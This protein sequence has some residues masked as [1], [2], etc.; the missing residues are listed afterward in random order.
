[1]GADTLTWAEYRGS[2]PK[3]E[4]FLSEL[5]SHPQAVVL[6][7]GSG[8]SGKSYAIRSA[9]VHLLGRYRMLGHP[10]QKVMVACST[11]PLLRDRHINK[12]AE[13][14]ASFGKIVDDRLYGL[15]FRFADESLGRVLFRNLDEPGKYRGTE[16]AAALVDELTELPEFIGGEPTLATLLYPIRSPRPLPFLPFGAGS[17]PDGVGYGWVKKI[18]VDRNFAEYGLKP[19]Q[20]KY[21]PALVGDNPAAGPEM[22]AR[23]EAL[24]ER[25]KQARLYGSWD[26]PEGARWPQL[27]KSVHMFDKRKDWPS[28]LPDGW[29]VIVGIDYGVNAPYA[30]LWIAIDPRGDCWVY[31]EDYEK[32]LSADQQAERVANLT[33]EN[34]TISAI[35]LDPAMWARGVTM[36][37]AADIYT[38]KFRAHKMPAPLPGF[39]RSRQ[40]AMSTIDKMLNRENGFGNLWIDRS[41]ENLW[42]EMVSAVWDTRGM[43]AG[44]REDIDPR[45][46]DH[47]I[48]A[49][50]YALHTHLQV[51]KDKNEDATVDFARARQHQLEE[52]FKQ[53][54]RSFTKPRGLPWR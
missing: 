33:A 31:R 40:I 53:S 14:M 36:V 10:A 42:R 26:A 28:G 16:V 54:V 39:N 25:L 44:K 18:F 5:E 38:D 52:R 9:A 15:S 2:S 20:V 29:N 34:E 41:C 21:V 23:L 49:L 32:N 8:A 43:L 24:P 51:P 27:E 7:G 17:N 22:V 19:E 6:Y 37:S 4:Q 50:Y 13:E 30:A 1:M 3:Q 47:A 35:Y 48:T 46:D 12:F 45:N 11:Y